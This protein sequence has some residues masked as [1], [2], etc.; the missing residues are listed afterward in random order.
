MI[1]FRFKIGKP[2][3]ESPEHPITVP[4]EH[5]YRLRSEGIVGKSNTVGSYWPLVVVA[6]DGRKLN[7]T[8]IHDEAGG[9][10]YY[11]I[12]IA[13]EASITLRSLL[14]REEYVH[15]VIGKVSHEAQAYLLDSRQEERLRAFLE[16]TGP[17][18]ETRLF[19]EIENLLRKPGPR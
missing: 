18:A 9:S 14:A 6:P 12:H 4:M 15:V 7:A 17:D 10:F 2:F 3:L 19:E 16:Y 13:G 8:V 1:S 5:S 11:Q